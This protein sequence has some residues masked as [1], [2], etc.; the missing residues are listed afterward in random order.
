MIS[1]LHY[2][3]RLGEAGRRAV[4][5]AGLAL[6]LSAASGLWLWWPAAGQWRQA[7][8]FKRD[9]I[10]GRITQSWFQATRTN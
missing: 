9:I 5:L 4:A 7:L 2:A 8:R 10:P 6:A 1:D 3:L